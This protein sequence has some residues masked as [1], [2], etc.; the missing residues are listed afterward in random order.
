MKILI[1]TERFFP[2]EFLI[3]DLAAEWQRQGHCVEVLTQVPSYP[4]DRIFDG[5]RNHLYQTTRE[6]HEI[7][8]HR[9]RTVLGYNTGGMK[10]KIVNYLNFA[11]WTS[12]WALL[13]GWRY[14]RVFAY[15]TGP[16]SMA[17]AGLIFHFIWWRKCMI[18]TQDIWPDTVY[19]YGVKPTWYMQAFLNIVVRG[20][21]TAFS[22]ITVSCPGFIARL[23]PYTSK[24][25]V[26]LAQWTTQNT[27]L[28]LRPVG[29]KKIF[30]FAGN[31]GS[32]QNLDKIIDAF[33]HLDRNDAELWIVGG[34]VYLNRLQ[35]QVADNQYRNIVFTGRRLHTEMPHFF[36]KSDVLIISLKPEFDLTIPGKFQAYIAAGRPI[37]GL[38]RGD[39]A[40]IIRQYDL[41]LTADPADS[42]S[43]RQA[44]DSMC[45]AAPE[46]FA[47]WRKN[48]LTLSDEHFNREKLIAQ[49]TELILK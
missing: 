5:Y 26:F 17:S 11:F 22:T 29:K 8:I 7:P 47:A 16:L 21:Y 38:I 27:P 44:F 25:I 24:K 49:F 19:S 15:H 13:N 34:G 4:H 45:N 6:Y 33:G 2:E 18:W 30:T 9:V 23:A 48:A 10:R 39:T 36:E 28:P 43:I 20:I 3:N 12:L 1:L 46:T 37:L 14:D 42:D 35:K 40:D 41:G 31:V 32:V